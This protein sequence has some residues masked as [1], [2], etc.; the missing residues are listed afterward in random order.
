MVDA[1]VRV[2]GKA[3]QP[4]A[5]P[6]AQGPATGYSWWLS[7]P[8]GVVQVDDGAPR[9]PLPGQHLGAA[10]SGPLRVQAGPGR[11]RLTARLARRWSPDDAMQTVEIDLVVD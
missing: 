3:G 10:V 8:A 6:M 4:V 5:L 9:T 11:Y 2:E 7:L 1:V